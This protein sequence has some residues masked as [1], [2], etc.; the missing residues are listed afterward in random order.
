MNGGFFSRINNHNKLGSVDSFVLIPRRWRA[1][2]K[3]LPP[4]CFITSSFAATTGVE[5]MTSTE[6]VAGDKC[7]V[8]R[9]V[10]CTDRVSQAP[11][12]RA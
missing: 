11:I 4:V 8:S 9:A 3:S 7:T 5:P 12:C 10:G 1:F 2:S 6:C